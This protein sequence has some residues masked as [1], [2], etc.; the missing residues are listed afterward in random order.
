MVIPLN[1][2]PDEQIQAI[3]W[4]NH[5]NHFSMV[6]RVFC[7]GHELQKNIRQHL[8]HFPALQRLSCVSCRALR[9]KPFLS[10]CL[11]YYLFI[12]SHSQAFQFSFMY[13]APLTFFFMTWNC[14]FCIFTQRTCYYTYIWIT[15]YK[16]TFLLY[17]IVI[18]ALGIQISLL[19]GTGFVQLAR[20][21]L[22][23]GWEMFSSAVGVYWMLFLKSQCRHR[24][25]SLPPI[26]TVNV[27]AA[28]IIWPHLYRINDVCVSLQ[29]F[30]DRLQF[31]IP[32]SPKRTKGGKGWS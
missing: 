15:I 32:H 5:S 20:S 11:V 16:D 27:E 28:I 2:K 19:G 13:L 18:T 9:K 7:R 1:L 14:P 3:S 4:Y 31:Y 25:Q 17:N 21:V 12:R 6:T 30:Q 26:T 22:T 10:V 8:Q 24:S 29:N 23:G